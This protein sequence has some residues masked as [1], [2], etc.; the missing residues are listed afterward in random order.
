MSATGTMSSTFS[1]QVATQ[2]RSHGD[3]SSQLA[4]SLRQEW[5]TDSWGRHLDWSSRV[6]SFDR[7]A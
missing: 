7:M 1:L 4:L 2:Q 5:K 6:G 3:R